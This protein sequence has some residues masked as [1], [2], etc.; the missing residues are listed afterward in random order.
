MLRRSLEEEF[1]VRLMDKKALIRSEV[2]EIS[3]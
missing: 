1:G 3:M 2:G